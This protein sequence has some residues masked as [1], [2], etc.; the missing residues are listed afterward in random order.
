GSGDWPSLER[1]R[2]LDR[3]GPRRSVGRRTSRRALSTTTRA[4]RLMCGIVAWVH[5]EDAPREP[6]LLEAMRSRAAH[7]G[8]DGAGSV[9]LAFA[10]GRCEAVDP[11]RPW[12]VALGHCRLSILDRSPAARQPMQVGGR[13]LVYNGEVYN[14][15]ELRH[16]LEALG[17][18]FSTRSDT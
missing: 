18:T 9:F 8:P 7:R 11:S 16:E 17:H 13:W 1:A 6:S 4:R 5:L 14:Y 3:S 12:R 15:I 10:G 2:A